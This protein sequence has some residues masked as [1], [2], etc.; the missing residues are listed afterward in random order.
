MTTRFEVSAAY[1]RAYRDLVLVMRLPLP[2]RGFRFELIPDAT[3]GV[4]VAANGDDIQA[5]K[6]GSLRRSQ[7]VCLN[8]AVEVHLR[9][10]TEKP[11][12]E[13]TK[14]LTVSAHGALILLNTPTTTG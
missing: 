5:A 1:F 9:R 2:V 8:V 14:T 13:Q 10:D 6:S 4:Q 7:R 12:W 3:R 11:S